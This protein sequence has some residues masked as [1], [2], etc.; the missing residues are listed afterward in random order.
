LRYFATFKYEIDFCFLGLV[1]CII[2]PDKLRGYLRYYRIAVSAQTSHSGGSPCNQRLCAGFNWPILPVRP[3]V[4]LISTQDKVGVSP[5]TA[6]NACLESGNPFDPYNSV[7]PIRED[8]DFQSLCLGVAQDASFA[9]QFKSTW[10]FLPSGVSSP[11]GVRLISGRQ[12]GVGHPARAAVVCS[13]RPTL[14]GLL[15]IA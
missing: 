1:G 5:E 10:R 9:I 12:V 14:F 13:D 2:C 7:S 4:S 8:S 11:V 3:A 15:A 6:D